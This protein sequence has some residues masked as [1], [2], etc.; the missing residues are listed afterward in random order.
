M[1]HVHLRWVHLELWKMHSTHYLHT[2][3]C[4]CT[5][6]CTCTYI[7]IHK[8][9]WLQIGTDRYKVH[10]HSI[11]LPGISLFNVGCQAVWSPLI[12]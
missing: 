2:C 5:Q 6:A 7:R 10:I 8:G 9:V 1:V 4:T 12:L 3:V 11:R